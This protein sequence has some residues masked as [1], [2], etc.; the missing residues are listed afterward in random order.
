[1]FAS[2]AEANRFLKLGRRAGG[3]R[4]HAFTTF[5]GVDLFFENHEMKSELTQREPL[6]PGRSGPGSSWTL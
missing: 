2:T 6:G 3:F 1:M 5:S 4:G